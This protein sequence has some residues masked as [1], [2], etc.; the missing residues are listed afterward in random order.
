V[1]VDGVDVLADRVID[2]EAA[3]G[4]TLLPSAPPARGNFAEDAFGKLHWNAT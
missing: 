3:H 4:A 2:A 1:T